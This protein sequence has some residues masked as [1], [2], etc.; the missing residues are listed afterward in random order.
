MYVD[1]AVEGSRTLTLVD[2]QA[3]G[4]RP[5]A[6]LARMKPRPVRC[7]HGNKFSTSTPYLEYIFDPRY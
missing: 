2:F 4:A 7:S 1:V 3:L 5:K 6:P